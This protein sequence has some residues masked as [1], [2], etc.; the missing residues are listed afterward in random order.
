MGI[1]NDSGA[2]VQLWCNLVQF[3]LHWHGQVV[4]HL[5]RRALDMGQHVRVCIQCD[6]IPGMAQPL[7]Y[8]YDRNVMTDHDRRRA[9]PQ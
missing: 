9:V 1:L 6:G 5:G 4:Q 7:A 3:Y 2:L 8:H